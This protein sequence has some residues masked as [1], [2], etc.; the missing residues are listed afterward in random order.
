MCYDFPMLTPYEQNLLDAISALN[1]AVNAIRLEPQGRDYF[2]LS[3]PDFGLEQLEQ[4]IWAVVGRRLAE[5][6]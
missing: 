3:V 4:S 6:S 2:S 1:E 5:G